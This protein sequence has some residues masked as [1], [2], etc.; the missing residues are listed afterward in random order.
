MTA[1]QAINDYVGTYYSVEYVRR[2]VLRQ[3]DTEIEE[4]D[5]QIEQ[6]KKDDIM[7]DDAGLQPGMAIGT[8]IPEP[9]MPPGNGAMPGQEVPG[10][11]EGQADA[12]QEYSGPETA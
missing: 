12:D 6:E 8:N 7:G 10:G 11:V 3:S 4:I 5:K 1:L 9:E 2:Y